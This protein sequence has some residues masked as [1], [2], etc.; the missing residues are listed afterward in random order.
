MEYT[1]ICAPS[2]VASPPLFPPSGGSTITNR[3]PASKH[4]AGCNNFTLC[5]V[6]RTYW[7][8]DGG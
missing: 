6:P 2:S 4:R 3:T 7:F 1:P 8:G 5:Q